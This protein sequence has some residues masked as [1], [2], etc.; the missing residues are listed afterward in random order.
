MEEEKNKKNIIKNVIKN[1]IKK[2][3]KNVI[4]IKKIIF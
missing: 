2:C 3:Y 4:E 1:V